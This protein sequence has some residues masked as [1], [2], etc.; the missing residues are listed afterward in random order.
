ME[1]LPM[2]GVGIAW[3]SILSSLCHVIRFITFWQN[4]LLHGSFNFFIVIPQ[5]VAAF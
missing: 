1:W 4:G 2:I 5:L 3:A